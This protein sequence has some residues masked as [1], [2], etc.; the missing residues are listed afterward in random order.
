MS[1]A[2]KQRSRTGAARVMLPSATPVTKD[3]SSLAT[4]WMSVARN[5]QTDAEASGASGTRKIDVQTEIKSAEPAT[6]KHSAS[7]SISALVGTIY[8]ASSSQQTHKKKNLPK[9]AKL[10][11]VAAKGVSCWEVILQS[12][13]GRVIGSCEETSEFTAVISDRTDPSQEDEVVTIDYDFVKASDR[14]LISEGAIF[15]WNIG[16]YRVWDSASE[17]LG[18]SR[19]HYEIRFRR[20]PPISKEAAEKIQRDSR[21]L[22]NKINADQPSAP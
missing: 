21:L 22:A 4:S 16:R 14:Q 10:Q 12:F 8:S 6:L 15:Y 18:P 13:V 7:S 5:L 3:I 17:K 1:V 9:F 11:A 19:N 20:L 2:R